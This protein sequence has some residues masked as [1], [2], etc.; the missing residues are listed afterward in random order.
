MI[1]AGILKSIEM[2]KWNS[3]IDVVTSGIK[4]IE[5]LGV[6][7]MATRGFGRIKRLLA[8]R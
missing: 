1:I 4:F 2:Y 3:P 5:Y 6:G 7:G 8:R